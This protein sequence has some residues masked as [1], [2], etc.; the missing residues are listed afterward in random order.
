MQGESAKGPQAPRLDVDALYREHRGVAL[1]VA[2][3]YLKDRE[4]AQDA[5]QEAFIRIYRYRDRIEHL[6]APVTWLCRIV[7]NV[8]VDRLRKSRRM[9]FVP[10]DSVEDD[11]A[12]FYS[13]AVSDPEASVLMIQLRR[14]IGE[15]LDKLSEDHRTV[16][17]LRDY[18][19]MSNEEIANHEG[20]PQGTV[21]SRLFHARRKLRRVLKRSRELRR[22]VAA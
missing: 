12:A 15:A 13:D 4:L 14:A 8:C 17:V 22:A 19:G 6:S 10:L 1:K 9:R 20:C 3:G 5:I 11:S 21:M 2:T 16:I 7:A 18:A